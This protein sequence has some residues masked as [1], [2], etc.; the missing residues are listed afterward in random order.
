MSIRVDRAVRYLLIGYDRCDCCNRSFMLGDVVRCSGKKAYCDFCDEDI[1]ETDIRYLVTESGTRLILDQA[2][3]PH[4]NLGV[5]TVGKQ[6]GFPVVK[7]RM[8]DEEY[9]LQEFLNSNNDTYVLGADNWVKGGV[10]ALYLPAIRLENKYDFWEHRDGYRDIIDDFVA[11]AG[12]NFFYVLDENDTVIGFVTSEFWRQEA[13]AV[14]IS[15]KIGGKIMSRRELEAEYNRKVLGKE[16]LTPEK[17][18]PAKLLAYCEQR[19]QGQ[20]SELKVAVFMVYK[21][22]RRVLDGTIKQADNWLLTAPSGSGKTEFFRCIRDVFKLYNVPIPVVQIDMSQITES[23]Y[24]GANVDTISKRI[25]AE[26][27]TKFGECICFLDEVDKKCRPSYNSQSVNIN[28]AVQGC[29]L[30]LVE[31]IKEEKFD[32]NKTMFVFMGAFQ[33]ARNSK[34]D[35]ENSQPQI[36][37][38]SEQGENRV[39]AVDDATDVFYDKLGIQ[40]IIDY[41]MQEELAG[42]IAHVVNFKKLSKADM[43]KLIIS[44]AKSISKELEMDIH[45]TNAAV[46][47]FLTISYGS[48]GIRRPMNVIKE[49]AINTVSGIFFEEGFDS[50]C[51]RI[52]ISGIDKAC[53]KKRK[54]K[55]LTGNT[56]EKPF[57]IIGKKTDEIAGE[58]AC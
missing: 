53:V 49:L 16:E 55:V 33:D 25:M 26:D 50:N 18:T 57:E 41:G 28:A 11:V 52:V 19:I 58:E 17:L 54:R 4:I 3:L 23:G 30:T 40:D 15:K 1:Q 45:L 47:E 31:G 10:F 35:K 22:M 5:Y 6:D 7:S 51:D 8:F 13:I 43:R 38:M 32:S 27:S 37:F 34:R 56:N 46:E 20:D 36:G 9:T 21:Y 44:K 42:R 14:Y 12:K 2:S 39:A 29:L 48:L 24:K